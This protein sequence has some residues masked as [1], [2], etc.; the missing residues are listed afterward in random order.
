MLIRNHIFRRVTIVGVG[1][2]GGSLGMAL[3]QHKLA[4]EVVGLSSRPSSLV[5]AIKVGAID[6]AITDVDKAIR[7]A[8]LVVLATPVES[9]IKL[10]PTINPFLRRGCIITDL[11][12]TKAEIVETAESLTHPSFFVGSHPLVGSE[13]KGVENA[14]ADLFDKAVC[15]MTPTKMTN[16]MIKEK[17]KYLWTK[18][19]AQVK[20]LLP[21]EHDEILAYV[22]HLPH[23][24]A[25]ALMEMI[26]DKYMEYGAGGLKD[27]TRIASSSPQIWHDIC[28]SNP[29]NVVKSL[30]QLVKVLSEIR[31]AIVGRDNRALM[32]HFMKGKEKR[33]AV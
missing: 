23:V 14:R 12:S 29:K 6:E 1:F 13:K 25:Y 2:M 9:I 15:L 17:V 10:F 20:F 27:T 7:H 28:F 33:D 21:E 26:P 31:K 18:L 11:G 19:G 4:R 24:L 22:S 5:E 30:D 3:R 16:P 32:N 8:D